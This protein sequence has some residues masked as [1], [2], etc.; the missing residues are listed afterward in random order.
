MPCFIKQR[1]HH[2]RNIEFLEKCV[3]YKIIHKLV[4]HKVRSHK[5]QVCENS[6]HLII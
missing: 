6:Y 4:L 5:P 1:D 2:F 3:D